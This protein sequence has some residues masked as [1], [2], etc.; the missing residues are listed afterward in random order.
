VATEV[1]NLA[2]QTEKATG[3][4]AAQIGLIQASVGDT[5]A[6]IEGI[7]GTIADLNESATAI[8][9][10]VQQQTAATGEIA[11]G[12]AEASRAVGGVTRSTSAVEGSAARS[13]EAAG[14]VNTGATDIEDAAAQLRREILSF[15]AAIKQPG[16][17]DEAK[18]A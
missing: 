5:V 6:I 7:G 12:V 18:A 13:A 1:K 14:V 16:A 17:S 9:S 8:A 15:L 4:I 11:A 3:E 2:A 10:A